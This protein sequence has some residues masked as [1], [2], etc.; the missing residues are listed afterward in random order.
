METRPKEKSFSVPSFAVHSARGIIRDQRTRRRTMLAL[1]GVAVPMAVL[2]STILQEA[3]S[4]REHPVRFILYW[5]ACAWLTVSALLLALFDLLMLR[6]EEHA[7]KRSLR[8][9]LTLRDDS[10]P[11]STGEEQQHKRD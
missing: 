1:L 2:G 6:T 5:F 10:R 11:F 8:S 7:R 3:L 9:D 4:P